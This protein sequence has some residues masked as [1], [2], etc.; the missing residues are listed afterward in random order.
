M[1]DGTKNV[2]V[3]GGGISGISSAL[4]LAEQGH[5][6]YL[7]ERKPMLGGHMSQL[8]KTFPTLDCAICILAPKM[9]EA[10]R[11]PRIHL[12]S[13]SEVEMVREDRGLFK[14]T[15]RRK[16]RYVDE[17]KCT[18]CGICIETC[19][20]KGVPDEFDEGMGERR[21]IY[22]PFPQAVPRVATIDPK[23]CIKLNEGKCGVCMKKCPSGAIDY[24]DKGGKVDIEVRSIVVATGFDMLYPTNLTRY[25]YGRCAN[26]ITSMQ[27][28]RML[29]ASGPTRGQVIRPSDHV[30]PQRIGFILCAGSRDLHCKDYCSKVCC[31]Y[32]TKDAMLTR[33]HLPEAE[34]TIFYNDL[35]A[36]G[37]GHEDFL[38]RGMNAPGLRYVG[39]L[40]GGVDNDADENLYV[41]YQ[42]MER[43]SIKE[44]TF[45]MVVLFTPI[46]PSSGSPE[47]ARILGIETDRHGFIKTLN[48]NPVATSREGVFVAGSAAGPDDISWSVASAMAA[49]S[50]AAARSGVRKAEEAHPRPEI[51][52]RPEDTPRIGV[53]VCSCGA[54]IGGVIDVDEVASYASQLPF[55]VHS[56]KCMYACSQENQKLIQE[57][58]REKGLNRVLIAACSPRSHLNLFRDTCRDAGLNPNLVGL[59]SI[60]ELDSWV[61]QSEP[62]RAT[63]KAKRIVRMGVWNVRYSEPREQLEGKV[64]P[65]AMVIGGGVAGMS[66]ALA[67]ASKG[68]KVILVERETEL[69]GASSRRKL[70]SL[71]GTAPSQVAKE[72]GERVKE[73]ENV[74]VLT[75]T[76]VVGVSG[77]VGAFTAQLKRVSSDVA[78]SLER[79]IEVVGAIIIATG[80]QDLE[81]SGLFGKGSV[82]GIV[83]QE[84]LEEMPIGKRSELGVVVQ[85]L[86]V[87]CRERGGREYCSITCCETSIRDLILLKEESPATEVYVLYRDIRLSG[88]LEEHYTKARELGIRFIRYSPEQPPTI[89]RMGG[90]SV[91]VRDVVL[92][93]DLR[94]DPDLVVLSTPLVPSEHNKRLSEMLKVPLSSDGFFLEAHP[95]LRP[96]DFSTEGVF[97]AGAAQGP[98]GVSQS[99]TQGLAAASRALIPLMKGKVLQ[100]PTTAMVDPDLCT[101]CARC[102]QAC[103]YG[104][105]GMKI[106]DFRVLAE[107][108][109]LMCKGC[110][111]CAVACP[112]RAVSVFNFNNDQIVSQID[113]AL[114]DLEGDE[115][116]VIAFLCNW[117]AYAGAENTGVSR[118]QYPPEILPIRV[119]CTGRVDPLYILYALLRG[120]DGVMVGG[121]HPGDCHYVS[122]NDLMKRRTD[123][124]KMMLSDHGMDSRRIRVEWVSAAE[125]KRFAEVTTDFVL[126]LRRLGPTPIRAKLQEGVV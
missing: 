107:V 122:G 95:K 94:I 21:A 83:G 2:L 80:A 125:G 91:K 79:R 47:L 5:E 13:Y 84:E 11:H 119:M 37:K 87:G 69:G 109:Q 34:V 44:E 100:E 59:T 12:L 89:E 6:V 24:Q 88:L 8:D 9:V 106:A 19:P 74:E 39:G 54:N 18:G 121:C 68:F 36:I 66:A 111:K 76:E 85:I 4:E 15:I 104:A 22:I 26:V 99:I 112:S 10:Y 78:D 98:K 31:M 126:Q 81:L 56:Q 71:N 40:P 115:V 90:L 62:E 103:P 72:L 114:A 53:Y 20:V 64:A 23:R 77:S 58:I 102:V 110:G 73:N 43:G 60:R 117:C 38:N 45:D 27:Y 25:G 30:V 67:I 82:P 17:T 65:A 123:R 7:V 3:I 48:S 97:V 108:N 75:S 118:F 93:R 113:Q 41:R 33:E 52:V 70:P 61:H 28:E 29:N 35:R 96:V 120:A 124:L 116:R 63:E 42:D 57:H 92:D 86:C 14:V 1:N 49:S 16:A 46:V 101:G 50:M 55:V 32:A 51:T 105:M